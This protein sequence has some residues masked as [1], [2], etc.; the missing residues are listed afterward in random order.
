VYY[1][2][3]DLA[4]TAGYRIAG[5]PGYEGGLNPA[6]SQRR[7]EKTN[8]LSPRR[9]VRKGCWGK[10]KQEHEVLGVLG[11]FAR[12]RKSMSPFLT[13]LTNIHVLHLS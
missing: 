4:I 12:E 6:F 2:Q 5:K 11:A 1:S 9:K 7:R 13:V 10:N 3:S 8:I